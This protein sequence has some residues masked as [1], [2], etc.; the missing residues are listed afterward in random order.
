MRCLI[1]SLS[2]GLSG[3]AWGQD[4]TPYEGS[5]TAKWTTQ[6]HVPAEG[7]VVVKG[8]AGTFKRLGRAGRDP[9]PFLSAPIEVTVATADTLSFTVLRSQA[10]Q[11]CTD[12]TLTLQRVE[13][14]R[15]QG[16][17]ASGVAIE[18]TR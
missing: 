3:A 17:F 10:L 1:L 2:L 16:S 8:M 7:A 15:L 13:A 18:L 12:S 14:N 6:N 5:W 9:C 11:G 4:T